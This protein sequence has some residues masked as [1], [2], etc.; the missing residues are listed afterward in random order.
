MDIS[1]FLIIIL[2]I[3]LRHY[4]KSDDFRFSY[5]IQMLVDIWAAPWENQ[6]SA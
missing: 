1:F 5:V 2:Y 4:P 6:Q 3:G